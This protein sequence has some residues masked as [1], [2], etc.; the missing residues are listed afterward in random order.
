MLGTEQ[1]YQLNPWRM[2]EQVDG[3]AALGIE[4]CV[5]GDQANVLSTELGEF[6]GFENIDANL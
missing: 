2:R 5:I 4:A 3:A 1:R 6:F